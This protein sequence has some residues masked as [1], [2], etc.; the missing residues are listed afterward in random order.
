MPK[1]SFIDP[2]QFAVE[3]GNSQVIDEKIFHKDGRMACHF[4]RIS[5]FE[6]SGCIVKCINRKGQGL[7]FTAKTALNR[8]WWRQAS[9]QVFRPFSSSQTK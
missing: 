8:C 9:I 3:R 2:G 1:T 7:P 4:P 6:E 5:L